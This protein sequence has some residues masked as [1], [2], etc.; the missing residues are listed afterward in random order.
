MN[1]PKSNSLPV[2]FLRA[3]ALDVSSLPLS[4]QTSKQRGS[5]S[6]TGMFTGKSTDLSCLLVVSHQHFLLRLQSS[7]VCYF[8]SSAPP[9]HSSPDQQGVSPRKAK[10]ALWPLF[11]PSYDL[12]PSSTL[13]P[14]LHFAS[15]TASH[16]KVR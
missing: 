12:Y 10:D 4:S 2:C 3:G 11:L 5:R 7:H 1:F 14:Y 9:Q 16:N 15:S 6:N 8:L 13:P